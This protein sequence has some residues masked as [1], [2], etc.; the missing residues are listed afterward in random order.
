MHNYN[1]ADVEKKPQPL[2]VIP[3]NLPAEFQKLP[4]WVLWRYELKKG[5]WTKVPYQPDGNEAKSNDP[6]TWHPLKDCLQVYP[7]KKYDGVGF[8]CFDGLT[9]IDKDHCIATDGT[10]SDEARKLV[11]S[12]D[13]YTEISPSGTGLRMVVWGTVPEAIKLEAIEIYSV[14]RYFTLTGHKL[15]DAPA[16]VNQRQE[17]VSRLFEFYR[18]VKPDANET[19]EIE[20][21]PSTGLADD[22]FINM[23]IQSHD[24]F[25]ALWHGHWQG[26]RKANGSPYGSQSEALGAFLAMMAFHTRDAAR[27]DRLTRRSGLVKGLDRIDKWNR[28]AAELI[29]KAFAFSPLWEQHDEWQEQWQNVDDVVTPAQENERMKTKRTFTPSEFLTIPPSKYLV[30]RHI[31]ENAINLIYGPSGAG[32]S[33]FALDLAFSIATHRPLFGTFSARQGPVLYLVSEGDGTFGPRMRAWAKYHGI[34]LESVKNLYLLPESFNFQDTL[35]SVKQIVNIIRNEVGCDPVAIFIDTLNRNI[36]GDENSPRDMCCFIETADALRSYTKAAI[37][38]V[39]HKGKDHARGP[40]GHSSLFAACDQ[41]IEV[42]GEAED[43]TATISCQKSKSGKPFASY[44]VNKTVVEL[45]ATD[46]D[47]PDSVVLTMVGDAIQQ[48]EK[49]D[50]FVALFPTDPAQGRTLKMVLSADKGLLASFK[51]N[52]IKTLK[53]H[54]GIAVGSGRLAVHPDDLH[55]QGVSYRYYRLGVSQGG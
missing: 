42:D 17:A 54:A 15:P 52:C 50:K 31:I 46:E 3:E 8:C 18:P 43:L 9:V 14:K 23:C 37:A 1:S 48:S 35:G 24:N 4:Y 12:L 10:I 7:K 13:T 2:A 51:W 5:K 47:N 38:V 49:M 44:I 28:L 55:K 22:E 36:H 30:S 40:R 6:G 45:D 20:V 39:H 29:R 34:S 53:K 21:D 11:Q 19:E 25:A 32:K 16:T 27:M 41:V 33:F 26:L